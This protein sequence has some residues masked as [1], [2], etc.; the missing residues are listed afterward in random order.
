VSSIACPAKVRLAGGVFGQEPVFSP[1]QLR[2]DS[3]VRQDAFVENL[4][5]NTRA[6]FRRPQ[7]PSDTAAIA[8]LYLLARKDA[9]PAIPPLAHDDDDVRRWFATV[10]VP[11]RQTWLAET[12]GRLV[13]VMVLDGDELDQL[14]VHPS[15][16]GRGV[17]GQLVRLAQREQ[18]MG[19]NLWTF[20]SNWRAQSF[21]ERNG[22][23]I[24][25]RT[26][27]SEN[28]ERAPDIRYSWVP[29]G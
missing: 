5:G 10:V 3:A 16:Q 2:P 11:E 23:R 21:Y 26:D 19:L 24:V 28:E 27:G 1:R 25:A 9:V 18:P 7:T 29:G 17:G 20:E 13:G 22:F 15:W 14:Y 12:D 4:A 8:E 6:R